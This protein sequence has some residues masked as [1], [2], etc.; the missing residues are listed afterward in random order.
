MSDTTTPPAQIWIPPSA[1]GNPK[2]RCQLCGHTFLESERIPYER[3]V[4]RCA[5][6]HHDELVAA[7]EAAEPPG[8]FKGFDPEYAEFIAKG[9]RPGGALEGGSI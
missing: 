6:E 1:R 8:L 7:V 3:H 9:G 5:D 4:A 2:Y